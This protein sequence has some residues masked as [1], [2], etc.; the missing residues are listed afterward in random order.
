MMS[1][2]RAPGYFVGVLKWHLQP[3]LLS[4][5]WGDSLFE[6]PEIPRAAARIDA[7]INEDTG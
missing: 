2:W 6:L 3:P 7:A 5:R 1:R 4:A